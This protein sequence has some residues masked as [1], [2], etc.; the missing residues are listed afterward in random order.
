MDSVL[1][2]TPSIAKARL[3]T[4]EV[5]PV[6]KNLNINLQDGAQSVKAEA[7]RYLFVA[8]KVAHLGAYVGFGRPGVVGGAN[9]GF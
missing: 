5:S 4:D 8:L 6:M 2:C 9:S 3:K 1:F 7:E